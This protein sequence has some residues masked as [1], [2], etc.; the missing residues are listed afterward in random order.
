MCVYESFVFAISVNIYSVNGL[1][2]THKEKFDSRV[3]HISRFFSLCYCCCTPLCIYNQTPFI[4]C[5]IHTQKAS[6]LA[7]TFFQF[8]FFSLCFFVCIWATVSHSILAHDI[9]S[10]SSTIFAFSQAYY[11]HIC[12]VWLFFRIWWLLFPVFFQRLNSSM[13]VNGFFASFVEIFIFHLRHRI[14]KSN[15]WRQRYTTSQNIR[16]RIVEKKRPINNKQI[17]FYFWHERKTISHDSFSDP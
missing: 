13:Q 17:M 12:F 15:W 3:H 6:P 1:C 16:T 8:P 5:T 9:P 4:V 10:F 14:A 11:K 7:T 2:A